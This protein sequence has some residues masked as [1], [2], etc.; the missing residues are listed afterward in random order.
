MN[1]YTY[2]EEAD[3]TQCNDCGAHAKTQE[4]VVHHKTCNPGE[5]KKWETFYDEANEEEEEE[6]N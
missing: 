1:T 3:V 4:G 6:W 5:S 2:I